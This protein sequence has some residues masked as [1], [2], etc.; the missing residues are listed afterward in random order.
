MIDYI[1]RFGE[2]FERFDEYQLHYLN[3]SSDRILAHIQP[4][5]P[6]ETSDLPMERPLSG[7]ERE[8]LNA[9]DQ[10]IHI[11]ECATD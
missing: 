3:E 2:S 5:K 10:A 7:F 4:A 6:S 1:D 11:R 9:L 8:I